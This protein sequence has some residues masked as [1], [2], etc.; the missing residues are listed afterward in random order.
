MNV[1]LI[2]YLYKL[3]ICSLTTTVTINVVFLHTYNFLLNMISVSDY[4]LPKKIN[5]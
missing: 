4:A 5:Q 3:E 2:N 1:T